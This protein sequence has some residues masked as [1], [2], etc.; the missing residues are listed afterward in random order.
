MYVERAAIDSSK[1][2][3]QNGIIVFKLTFYRTW[4]FKKSSNI[5]LKLEKIDFFAQ[6][7]PIYNKKGKKGVVKV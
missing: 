3:I 4:L 1:I 7:A 2:D 5:G 6:K